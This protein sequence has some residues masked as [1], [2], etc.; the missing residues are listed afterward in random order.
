MLAN[1]A[2]QYLKMEKRLIHPTAG[3]STL[4]AALSNARSEV[5]RYPFTTRL[6]RSGIVTRLVT[7]TLDALGA[8]EMT[9][10]GSGSRLSS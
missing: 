9:F 2:P 6:P 10:F 8:G 5:A 7:T 4:L 1:G 3:K